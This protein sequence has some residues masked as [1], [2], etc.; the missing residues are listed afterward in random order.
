[1]HNRSDAL[2]AALDGRGCAIHDQ[3]TINEEWNDFCALNP[4]GGAIVPLLTRPAPEFDDVFVRNW[5][6]SVEVAALSG[7]SRIARIGALRDGA[8]AFV[9]LREN[10]LAV[11]GIDILEARLAYRVEN[12]GPRRIYP[13]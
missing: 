13:R 10:N 3:V 1:M 2:R 9:Q 8:V 6:G 5:L 7:L 4:S 11:G 12:Q